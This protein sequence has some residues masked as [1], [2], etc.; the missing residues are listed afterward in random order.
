MKIGTVIAFFLCLLPTAHVWG[1]D[2]SIA[3]R[4]QH[5]GGFETGRLIGPDSSQQLVV[6]RIAPDGRKTDLTRSVAYTAVP[7]GKV[8]IEPTGLVKP[9]S[10]GQVEI[11]VE[12]DDGLTSAVPFVVE[13][14]GEP[15]PLN[16]PND[17]VPIFTKHGCNGGGCHGKASGQNGF[18]LSLLGF[19]PPEDFDFLVNE[20]R[21]RRLFPTAPEHSLLLRKATGELPHGGGSRL[22]RESPDYQTLVRWMEQS[23]P[24]GKP[25]DPR[26]KSIEVFPRVRTTDA[27]T[28]QQ[29]QV[30]A[31]YTD[32]TR[33]DITRMATYESNQ[34]DMAEVDD[35]GLVT[36]SDTPGDTA[37]MIRFKDYVDVFRATIPLGVPT[38][39][40]PEPVNFVDELVFEKLRT[41]GL[42][43]SGDSDDATF[44]RRATLDIAGRLPTAGEVRSFAADTSPDKRSRLIDRLLDSPGYAD[45]FANKWT[46]ILRNKRSKG[47]YQRGT[48]AFHD[49]IRN[50]LAD[51]KP[52]NEI[53]G[54]IVSA[55]GEI[56][57]NPAVAWFR[58]VTKREE[59]LQDV[60]QV[61]LGVRMQ[62]AQCHHHP[63]EKWSQ[64]D[65]F[66]LAAFFSQ[67]GK[68]A[69]LQPG[70]QLVIHRPGRATA[71]N[72]KTG[73]NLPPK[74]LGGEPLDLGP[75]DD[76]RERLA[77]WM[78]SPDNPFFARMLA[79]RYWKH[80]FGRGL[81][82]P[83]DDVRLTNPAVNPELLDALAKHFVEINFD[84]KQFIRT[85]CNSRTYQRT[86]LPNEHNAK[87]KQ[88]FS[89]F[90]PRRLT[91][92]VLLDSIDRITGS[93]TKFAGLP[94]G[95][96]AVQLPDDS[97]N[98]SS[99][100]LTVFGRPENSSAC[101]C[102]RT[103]DAN[104]AQSLHLLNSK[105][106]QDKLVNEQGRAAKYAL[107]E[108]MP[109]ADKIEDIY[110][111]AF[112]R[113]PTDEERK[114][115]LD[116]I[117]AKKSESAVEGQSPPARQ[118]YEDI[119]WA[120][121]NTKEFL[122]NH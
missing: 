103:Q 64:D 51:N 102:E 58:S 15:L 99:Y 117:S 10:D 46:A 39:E 7:D 71:K 114:I 63:Y 113:P 54:R 40:L 72:P 30:T 26:V 21:G 84:L 110:H 16:F 43:P 23:M 107:D 45:Y 78:G 77:Q 17:I 111:T 62:C 91:A 50:N 44:L 100:F 9:L 20:G 67:I 53:A 115:A 105:G 104:L 70:E 29:L 8:K 41:L 35:H 19:E 81:V 5:G 52:F 4:V 28:S 57:H 13:H 86:A 60:A 118:A 2:S 18:R 76:P 101:E 119:L 79:N 61:F 93:P 106:I 109:E 11:R 80:F 92:E 94:L 122:F 25:D 87:D 96:K 98:S 120:L 36:F 121:I 49:W 82:E 73:K 85:L 3:L 14:T 112:A 31:L 68:K 75:D 33:R 55:K 89:R 27:N 69:G 116:Y 1:Q 90:Y 66:G 24:Y 38:G 88:N 74:P 47:N 65:Y 97:F 42:P 95:T 22:N 12:T 48:F 59:Q 108:S 56:G 37:I 34:K 32:N 83:E 6:T